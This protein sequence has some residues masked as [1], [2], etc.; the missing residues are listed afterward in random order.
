MRGLLSLALLGL[1]AVTHAKES[2]YTFELLGG[3]EECFAEQI[4]G[5]VNVEV[6]WE[7][8][9]GSSSE[10]GSDLG[11]AMYNYQ[12]SLIPKGLNEQ[13]SSYRYLS[14]AEGPVKICF[15]NRNSF[16]SLWVYFEVGIDRDNDDDDDFNDIGQV[17]D[18][19][20]LEASKQTQESLDSIKRK[21]LSIHQKLS[22]VIR[23]QI[24]LKY[25]EARHRS[26]A[27]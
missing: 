2:M 10:D 14:E 23:G 21:A 27:E 7:V 5:G 15:Y 12:G 9:V 25:R 16:Q 26:T 6:D 20:L 24:Y 3:R 19:A 22:Q 4:K 11:V 8:I 13:H 1:F 18:P 17:A